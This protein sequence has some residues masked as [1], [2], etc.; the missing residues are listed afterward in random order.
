MRIAG[1]HRAIVATL[2]LVAAPAI[3]APSAEA[4]AAARELVA[5]SDTRSQLQQGMQQT[6]ADM[7]SGK[8]LGAYIDQN[9]QMRLQRS[10]NPAAWDAALARL[11][12]K[13]ATQLEILM[14]ELVPLIEER[15]VETY[16]KHFS[17]D[18]LRQLI[19]FH[20]SPLGK[21]VLEKV[22]AVMADSMALMQ[23]EMPRRM[24]S[25]MEALA[26]EIERELK[27]LLAK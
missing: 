3:A 13:Q 8:A 5:L 23:T 26:P 19:A 18:E 24:K 14:T 1:L 27:P 15:S 20:R 25:M 16:A 21:L 17:V 6:F 22:P 2:L 10:R 12:G 4:L 7:R 11:G 9:P